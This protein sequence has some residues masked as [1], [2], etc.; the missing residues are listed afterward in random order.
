MDDIGTLSHGGRDNKGQVGGF[1][2]EHGRYKIEGGKGRIPKLGVGKQHLEPNQEVNHLTMDSRWE[3]ELVIPDVQLEC[4]ERDGGRFGL[5]I[6]VSSCDDRTEQPRN[7]LGAEHYE[8][9]PQRK[10]GCVDIDYTDVGQRI[11]DLSEF[12]LLDGCLEGLPDGY[13]IDNGDC[14]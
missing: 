14:Q 5:Y 1:L 8:P 7:P 3:R 6:P 10:I 9:L 11:Q 13:E 2:W 12:P 4:I